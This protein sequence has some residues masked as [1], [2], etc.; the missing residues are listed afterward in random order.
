MPDNYSDQIV[1]GLS[2]EELVSKINWHL[3]RY[4]SVE[5][6]RNIERKLVMRTWKVRE[7]TD[8]DDA[9]GD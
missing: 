3:A 1:Q 6:F 7:V 5:L 9:D 2:A 4:P 8:D